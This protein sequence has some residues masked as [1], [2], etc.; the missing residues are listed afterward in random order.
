MSGWWCP[1]VAAESLHVEGVPAFLQVGKEYRVVD[2]SQ[3]VD[4]PPS[5]ADLML[6]DH[7]TC[8]LSISP[9]GY[10]GDHPC[11]PKSTAVQS[12]NDEDQSMLQSGTLGVRQER[13]G[14]AELH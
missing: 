6:K 3:Y 7:V 10:P 5:Q 13:Y 1:R 9:P 11:P 4:I 14:E 8:S 12:H 2:V